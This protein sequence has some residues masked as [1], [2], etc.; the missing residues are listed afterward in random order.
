MLPLI[1]VWTNAW[2]N[3]RDAGDLRRYRVHYDVTVMISNKMFCH[4]ISG[5]PNTTGLVIQTTLSHHY[6]WTCMSEASNKDKDTLLH[7]IDSVGCYYLSLVLIPAS[8]IFRFQYHTAL[9]YDTARSAT[10]TNMGRAFRSKKYTIV[11]AWCCILWAFEE[12]IDSLVFWWECWWY[13]VYFVV[14]VSTSLAKQ[15]LMNR[16][17]DPV[18]L[19]VDTFP[20]Q[21]AVRQTQGIRSLI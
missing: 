18:S 17:P 8:H 21:C 2:V 6:V 12:N 13:V 10:P 15:P 9:L 19:T 20:C 1:C 16:C 4:M 5:S 3:N 11:R 7:P 14:I